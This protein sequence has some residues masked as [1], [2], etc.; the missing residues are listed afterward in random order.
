MQPL[1]EGTHLLHIGPQKTGSTAIQAAMHASREKLLEHGVVYPGPGPRPREAAEV[2]LGFRR[3]DGKPKEDQSAWHELLR[4]VHEPGHRRVCVSLEAFG[5]ANDEQARRVVE[6]LGGDRPHVLA[7]A[8]RYDSLMP[9]QWQQRVKSQMNLSYEEWLRIVLGEPDPDEPRWSNVW[10][11]HDTVRLIERWTALV[12]PE[13]FTLVI[14]DEANRA[15]L[16][17]TFEAL[18]DLPEGMLDPAGVRQNQS[19]T[20]SQVE[21]VRQL[22]IAF[23]R[24]GWSHADYHDLVRHGVVPRLLSAPAPAGEPRIPAL[25]DWARERIVELS[26]QRIADLAN[27]PVRVVGS[28]EALRVEA[29]A[30]APTETVVD[31]TVSVESAARALEGACR[32]AIKRQ[33]AERK[34]HRKALRSARRPRKVPPPARASSPWERVSRAVRARLRSR[35]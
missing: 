35:A 16:P 14:G 29:H 32:A 3:L 15:Q 9:S 24:N 8:R 13:N 12:G 23:D 5:R 28:L 17:R 31:D 26:D 20:Y 1:P 18:L 2:G 34:E 6:E 33:E 22:N 10:V 7:V 25:P 11:P 4:Q 30:G 19:L 27:V 21:V